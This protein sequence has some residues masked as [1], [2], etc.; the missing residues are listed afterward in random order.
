MSLAFASLTLGTNLTVRAAGEQME[1]CG[2]S[3]NVV[4]AEYSTKTAPF[5]ESIAQMAN[6]QAGLDVSVQVVPWNDIH[7]RVT[8]LIQTGQRPD[9]LNYDTWA[10]H[11]NDGL[12]HPT[13]DVLSD[14]TLADL[15]P[16]FAASGVLDGVG[17]GMP[18]VA[19]DSLLYYNIDLFEQA[20]I[21]PPTNWAELRA[22]A[23]A[24]SALEGRT[25][26]YALA[27]G[28]GD[29][30]VDFAMWIFSNGGDYYA[31]GVW[32]I[33]SDKN[34]ETMTFLRELTDAGLTQI[35]PG[36]T[37]R[38]DG[39]WALFT[40]GGAGMT[41]AHGGFG[42]RIRADNPD[43]N[44][45][46][47][48]MPVNGQLPLVSLGIADYAMAFKQPDC[49]N[50]EALR[51][52][53]SVLWNPDNLVPWVTDEGFLPTTRSGVERMSSIA[54]V[55]P[56]LDL[57]EYAKFAP[58]TQPCYDPVIGA[59]KNNIGLAMSSESPADV[60]ARIQAASDC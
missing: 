8:T 34:V 60:L 22:A 17:Y 39:T 30:Q 46:T 1:S 11:A 43:L 38:V 44:W 6:D 2:N 33:D 50:T 49:D 16:S 45:G 21:D 7:Q 12:L 23:E 55:K 5:W 19:S 24:I 37:N 13:Q 52:F 35:N 10:N 29:A 36:N 51:S 15:I 48:P 41:I 54:E 59:V 27:L 31:D 14:E 26:G 32:V 58:T 42:G 28:P 25:A 20:G 40:R 18:F 3:L 9:V 56:F 47:T 4:A 53:L 57:L